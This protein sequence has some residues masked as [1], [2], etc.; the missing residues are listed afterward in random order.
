MPALRTRGYEISRLALYRLVRVGVGGS[1]FPGRSS[2]PDVLANRL[3][4]RVRIRLVQT[5]QDAF[6]T[7][8]QAAAGLVLQCLNSVSNARRRLRNALCRKRKWISRKVFEEVV[9]EASRIGMTL[10]RGC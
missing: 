10:S 7:V 6:P 1:G 2:A 5:A 9:A 8:G 4:Q 3:H